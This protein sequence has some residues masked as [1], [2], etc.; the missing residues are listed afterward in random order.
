MTKKHIAIWVGL[1]VSAGALVLAFWGLDFSSLEEQLVKADWGVT[2]GL[3]VVFWLHFVVRARRWQILL[4]PIKKVGFKQAFGPMLIGFFGNNLLPAHMGEFARM[5]VGA[6]QFGM[7]NAQVL[8][9]LVVERVMDFAA[10]AVLFGIGLSL[11]PIATEGLASLGYAITVAA[12]AGVVLIAIYVR[13]QQRARA[14]IAKLTRPLPEHMAAWLMRN[15]DAFGEGL[16]AT[17]DLWHLISMAAQSLLLW[18]LMTAALY[19]SLLAIDVSLPIHASLLLLGATVFAVTL[20]AAPGFFGT[21]QL[22]YVL[23]LKPYG[24]SGETAVAASVVFH[25]PT[26]ISVTLAGVF[27]LGR[28][29]LSWRVV[30]HEAEEIEE[31][32][33]AKIIGDVSEAKTRK[34]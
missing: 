20:P 13:Y 1:L 15:V 22:A 10:V 4:G 24:L 34:E 30:K 28:L 14:F 25:L 9:T 31:A 26:Y 23:A 29:G 2:I 11:A 32:G 27:V 3:L 5:Y 19:L 12:C 17:S 6:R 18:C 8:A 7:T 33:M 21:F 16:Q